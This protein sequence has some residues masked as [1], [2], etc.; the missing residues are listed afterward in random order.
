M[1]MRAELV[2]SAPAEDTWVVVGER[3]GEIGEW[4]SPITKSS[5][6]GPPGAG[7]VRTC[8][9]AGFGPLPPG[10]IKERLAHFDPQ[11]RSLSYE[12]AAGM[13]G[14]IRRAV[15]RWLV[16]AGPGGAS[17]VRIHATLTLLPVIRPPAAPTTAPV[18]R[19]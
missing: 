18:P 17:T 11:A 12:A 1:E 7:R 15:N 19:P 4:A 14:I 5:M 9:V 2:I 10:V 16:H 3:F 8:H 13:P 6:D